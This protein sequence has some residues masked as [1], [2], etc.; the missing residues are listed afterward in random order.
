MDIHKGGG[1]VSCRR[2]W[3]GEGTQNPSLSCGRHTREER[4][5]HMNIFRLN[6][7]SNGF[8]GGVEVEPGKCGNLTPKYAHGHYHNPKDG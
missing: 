4:V 8:V 7:N 1:S 6:D 3:P 5:F 2:I